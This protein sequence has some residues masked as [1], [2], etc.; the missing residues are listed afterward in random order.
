MKKRMLAILM[1]AL[2]GISL[3]ACGQQ[4]ESQG[5]D[6]PSKVRIGI[7]RVPNDTTVAIQ[8]QYFDEYFKNRGIETEFIFFDSGV[9]A[10]QAFLSG[11]IDFAEM[12]FTNGVVAL[13]N[14]LPVKLIW[15]HE[16]IG[17]NEALIVKDESIQDVADLKGKKVATIFSSTA[18][19][20]L[21][22]S[23]EMNG[24]SDKDLTLLN[25]DTAEIV[26]AWER[27]DI[28]AAYTWE[29]TLSQI[30][31]T[32]KTLITSADLAEQGILTANIR[33]VHTNF[34]EK[35]PD[36]TAD[37]I[38]ALSKAGVLYRENPE[39]AIEAAADYIGISYDEAKVQMEGTRWLTKEEQI[40]SDYMGENGAFLDSFQ[41]TSDYWSEQGFISRALSAEEIRD[42]ID[43]SYIEKSMEG[44]IG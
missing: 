28:D 15:I 41:A 23:L 18:H 25:M 19:F 30:G 12:G 11:A 13:A 34:A 42:F 20:S 27:G 6:L 14:E 31:S 43:I 39:D 21:L 7:I 16:I 37:F 26:A 24:L 40:S 10:N 9:S 22:K 3:T 32:G 5:T 29:P 2:I 8:Q 36:L 44:E 17:T 35:Y 1:I 4:E 38:K 33:L